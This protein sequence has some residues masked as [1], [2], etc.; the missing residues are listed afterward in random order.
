[1]KVCKRCGAEN[2]DDAKLCEVCGEELDV[3][4]NS[5]EWVLLLTSE[6]QFEAEVVGGLLE[7]NGINVMLKRPG[8]GF[9]ISSPFSNPLLGGLGKFNVFVMRTDLEK[10]LE[11][12][13]SENIKT[14]E[15]QNGTGENDNE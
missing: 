3:D 4:P 6:N 10:A 7:Q 9:S 13:K 1:M 14:E 5:F 2:K 8:S 11:L 15:E 12:I